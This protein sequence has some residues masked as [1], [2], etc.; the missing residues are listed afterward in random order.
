M[1]DRRPGSPSDLSTGCAGPVI[2]RSHFY[3]THSPFVH[4]TLIIPDTSE[5]TYVVKGK[6]LRAITGTIASSL[7]GLKDTDSSYRGFFLFPELSIRVEGRYS[8]RFTLF[9]IID[10]VVLRQK[11]TISDQFMV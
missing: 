8:L 1:V 9:E 7:Y 11:S 5:E 3:R 4:A 2:K 6:S 10:N